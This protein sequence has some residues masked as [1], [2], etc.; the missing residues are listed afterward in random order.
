V[1]DFVKKSQY[2]YYTKSAFEKVADGIAA[3]A[4]KEGLH[5]HARS[6]TIR[7]ETKE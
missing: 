6:A 1:D 4:D 2:V 3:F 7:F 5:A